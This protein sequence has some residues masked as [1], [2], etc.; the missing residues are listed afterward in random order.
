MSES[1]SKSTSDGDDNH[2]SNEDDFPACKSDLAASRILLVQPF[3]LKAREI[4]L[5][6][7][8]LGP[9]LLGYSGNLFKSRLMIKLL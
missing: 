6:H 9:L 4:L 7:K 8:H 3:A 5:I 1:T 2:S